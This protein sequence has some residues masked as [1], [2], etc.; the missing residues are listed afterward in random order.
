MPYNFG[1]IHQTVGL[2]KEVGSGHLIEAT[3]T[4]YYGM[5]AHTVI[6][7]QASQINPQRILMVVERTVCGV[8]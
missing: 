2:R 6:P 3:A 7:M 1:H 8:E 4:N 5:P